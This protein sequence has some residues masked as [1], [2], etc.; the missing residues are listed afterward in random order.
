VWPLLL[1][2]LS[3]VQL[4]L[5]FVIVNCR[6]R[7]VALLVA[8]LVSLISADPDRVDDA[9]D[10]VYALC[11]RERRPKKRDRNALPPGSSP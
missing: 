9:V 11:G 5:G 10:L 4:A 3:P 6:P 2:H 7:Q 8:V 1:Q